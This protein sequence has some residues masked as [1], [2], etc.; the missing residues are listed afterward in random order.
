MKEYKTSDMYLAAYLKA[1]GH[2]IVSVDRVNKAKFVFTMTDELDGI[3]TE[4]YN[5]EG[6]I[7]PLTYINNIRAVKTMTFSS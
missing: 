2:R 5:E 4:Y 7:S 1:L 3:I 6:K